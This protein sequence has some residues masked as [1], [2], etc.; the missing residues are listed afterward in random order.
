MTQIFSNIFS[1]F[2]NNIFTLK[3]FQDV[4]KTFIGVFLAFWVSQWEARRDSQAKEKFLLQEIQHEL[5]VNVEDL[6]INFIGHKGAIESANFLKR[7]YQNDTTNM[8]SL[9]I[10]FFILLNDLLSIQ[11]TAAYETIKAR[12]LESILDD[13]LRLHIADLYDFDFEVIEKM[14]DHYR[15][16]DFLDVYY[17]PMLQILSKCYDFSKPPGAARH[18]MFVSKLPKQEQV[19][20]HAW[21]SKI[22]YSHYFAQVNY[23]TTIEKAEKVLADI[24]VLTTK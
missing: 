6:R 14:E 15:P 3:F 9:A 18:I 23:Q 2:S 22:K 20:L 13:S 16:N 7:Y 1:F 24:K 8:D 10:H 21:L 11:H 12:G 5:Q 4:L 17:Q 19:L